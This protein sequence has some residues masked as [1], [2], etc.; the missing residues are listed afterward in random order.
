M[1][2]TVCPAHAETYTVCDCPCT[3]GAGCGQT[4]WI[5]TVHTSN[6]RWPDMVPRN[7]FRLKEVE[8]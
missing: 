7:H 1:T 8:E 6:C 5:G 4:V 2:S 3:C